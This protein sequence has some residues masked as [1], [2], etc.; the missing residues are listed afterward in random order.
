MS[1]ENET[2]RFG[3]RPISRGQNCPTFPTSFIRVLCLHRATSRTLIES[4]ESNSSGNT[5]NVHMRVLY[6][7]EKNGGINTKNIIIIYRIAIRSL[8]RQVDRI[9]LSGDTRNDRVHVARL[10]KLSDDYFANRS[11]LSLSVHACV[12]WHAKGKTKIL[13]DFGDCWSSWVSSIGIGNVEG[14]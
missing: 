13:K 2:F 12:N 11:R 10:W 14:A 7:L 4:R 6:I 9:G 3:F 1:F 8:A 5:K